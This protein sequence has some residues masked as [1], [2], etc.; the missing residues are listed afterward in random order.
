MQ[1]IS[2]GDVPVRQ[3]MAYLHDFV[4]S[5]IA[6]LEFEPRNVETF[7]YCLAARRI[8]GG[9]MV[10]STRYSA[11]SGVRR[12]SMLADGRSNYVLSIHDTDYEVDIGGRRWAVGAGDIMVV[13]EASPYAFRLPGTGA[14]IM[15]LDRGRL[16]D[17][18]PHVA[19]AP[20]WHVP[21]ASP[22]VSLVSGYADLLRNL[23]ESEPTEVASEHVYRLVGAL[24]GK[25]DEARRSGGAVSQARLRLIK[26]DIDL[27]LSEPDLSLETLARRHKVTPRYIQLLFAGEGTSFSDHVRAK[28]LERAWFDLRDDARR[29]ISIAAI[30]FEAGFGDLSSFNRAFRRH[31]GT[32]PREVRA[33]AM[34]RA[35]R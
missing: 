5:H 30:A 15:A 32:T 31:F 19:S 12:P 11:V 21:L 35:K 10:S 7:D 27:L 20:A 14:M 9:V 22:M 23:P 4:A 16:L 28:R 26:A 3:R 33:D 17:I 8:S 1:S 29:G 13:D 25:H 18:A 2:I 6:G 24:I 34:L